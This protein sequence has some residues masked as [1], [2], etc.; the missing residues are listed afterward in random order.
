MV[1]DLE[2]LPL[3][4]G[5]EAKHLALLRPL[6]ER[7]RFAA[8]ATVVEQGEAAEYLYLIEEG[9]IAICYKP[10]DGESI[11][12]T[13]VEAGGLF[14]WSAVVGS[15]HYTSSGVAVEEVK[16]LRV[17]GSDLRRLCLK[18]P[19]AGVAILDR[20]ADAVSTRWKDAHQQIRAV[21][22]SGIDG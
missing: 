5:L 15:P 12:I 3:F 1:P 8:G 20:L 9:R 13:H 2:L 7:V 19:E 18:H 11:T 17:R 21:I 16:A 4:R 22:K 6:F 14:G 10:Y